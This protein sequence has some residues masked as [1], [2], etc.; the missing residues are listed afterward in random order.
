MVRDHHDTGF[1]AWLEAA[2]A[3]ELRSF[4]DEIDRDGAAVRA[5]LTEPWNTS[6]VEGHINRVKTIKHQMYGRANYDLL[7]QRVRAAA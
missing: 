2:R 6:P 7:R 1:D 3:S 5:A 4:A